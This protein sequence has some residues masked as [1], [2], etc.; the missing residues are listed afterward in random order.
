MRIPCVLLSFFAT[1]SAFTSNK[2]TRYGAY[3]LTVSRP[4]SRVQS[5]STASSSSDEEFPTVFAS[6]TQTT[7]RDRRRRQVRRVQKYARL[8]VWPVWNG[9]FIWIV[10]K[11]LGDETAARLEDAITGRVCPNFFEYTETSPF[12]MLVHHCH[13]FSPID[14]LRFLQKSFFPEGFPAHPHRGEWMI[15]RAQSLQLDEEDLS[16]RKCF[17]MLHMQGSLQ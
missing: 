15:L 12:V 13:S 10:Q 9:V 14:P 11:I 8:P 7:S 16:H 5:R 3:H 1:C 17:S 4:Y 6:P 2:P